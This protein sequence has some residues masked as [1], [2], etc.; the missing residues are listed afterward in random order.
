LS[1]QND[2]GLLVSSEDG[3]YFIPADALAKFR[4]TETAAETIRSAVDADDEVAGF[5]RKDQK[6]QN[7]SG[8]KSLDFGFSGKMSP[9]IIEGTQYS[10][11]LTQ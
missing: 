11:R 5:G 1:E 10:D 4:M 6:V 2:D 8:L 3:V 7:R 9:I